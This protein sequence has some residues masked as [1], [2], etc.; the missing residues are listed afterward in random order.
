MKANV[1]DHLY[2][3]YRNKNHPENDY[4][5]GEG[6]VKK[7]VIKDTGPHYTVSASARNANR[8][9]TTYRDGSFGHWIFKDRAQ[10]V[11][12]LAK[13]EGKTQ[14]QNGIE[15]RF[16]ILAGVKG[17][18]FPEVCNAGLHNCNGR[19]AVFYDEDRLYHV[20]CEHCGYLAH[21]RLPSYLKAKEY[22]GF[23]ENLRQ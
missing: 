15:V 17:D 3:I 4:C 16:D 2:V 5:L 20:E 6:I 12:A 22:F 18:N 13:L 23:L 14:R 10:A 1:G 8:H 21:E 19:C 9:Y 7:I 11:R